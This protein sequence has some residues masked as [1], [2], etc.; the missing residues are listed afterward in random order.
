M[1]LSSVVLPLPK[2]P[3]ITVT[4]SCSR[5]RA[6]FAGTAH[7]PQECCVAVLACRQRVH[8]Q[9]LMID[10]LMWIVITSC[11]RLLSALLSSALT[12]FCGLLATTAW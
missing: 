4:G 6:G 12:A 9:L 7:Q 2:K 11:R 10:S 3:V 1:W 5:S 8:C